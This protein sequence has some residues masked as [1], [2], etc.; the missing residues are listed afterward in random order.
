M[1]IFQQCKTFML[2]KIV[3]NIPQNQIRNLNFGRETIY[4]SKVYKVLTSMRNKIFEFF[5]QGC[6]L[7]A[8]K[9]LFPIALLNLYFLS[10]SNI[11]IFSS[12]NSNSCQG[13]QVFEIIIIIPSQYG[14]TPFSHDSCQ[15]SCPGSRNPVFCPVIRFFKKHIFGIY[16]L[17]GISGCKNF[18]G[19]ICQ[20]SGFAR[21]LSI[22]AIFL[23]S[24]NMSTQNNQKLRFLCLKLFPDA[25]IRILCQNSGFSKSA[26]LEPTC[27]GEFTQ[28]RISPEQILSRI[29]FCPETVIFKPFNSS[30]MYV[31]KDQKVRFLCPYGFLQ[32]DQAC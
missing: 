27:Y 6:I 9:K 7:G 14:S 17:W 12:S 2:N 18:P 29:R 19:K 22:S 32:P 28:I 3:A 5:R 30:Y 23:N 15:F 21:K 13:S 24:S 4:C 31:Q 26:Y 10:N 16:M 8:T 25:G 20:G 1:T 11:L